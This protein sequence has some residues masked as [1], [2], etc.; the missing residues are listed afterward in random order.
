MLRQSS[1]PTQN[2]I[3]QQPC[4]RS[5]KQIWKVGKIGKVGQV[6]KVGREGLIMPTWNHL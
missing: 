6:V 3:S 2:K 1:R 5:F 4:A